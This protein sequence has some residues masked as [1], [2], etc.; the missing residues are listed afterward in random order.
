MKVKDLGEFGLIEELAKM[1]GKEYIGDDA[2]V[3]RGKDGR[4]L[5]YSSD[6]LVEGVHFLPEWHP[7]FKLG[8]KAMCS[9]VSDIA[10]MGG[11]AEY[12]L[13]SIAVPE[14]TELGWVK[15]LYRGIADTG[16]PIIGGDTV[17]GKE[18]VISISIIGSTDE[19]HL[20]TRSGAK[21]GDHVLVSGPLGASR[22]GLEVLK[23]GMEG[24]AE[25]VE[26]HLD[27]GCRS[28]IGHEVGAIANS[29]IDIS[30]GLA[31]EIRHIA[32]MSG[33]GAELYA[34]EIPIHPSAVKVSE[35]LGMDALRIALESGEEYE[36]LFTVPEERLEEARKYGTVIGRIVDGGVYLVRD[37]KRE[38]IG[39]GW[40]QF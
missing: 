38:D 39:K 37:G 20:T 4:I 32:E 7:P 36:L 31:S 14:N 3:V 6:M 40:V 28:D 23:R 25:A 17:R 24:Y 16:V 30:D 34:E 26:K 13:V 8:R 18:V 12:A 29:M 33:V 19:E 35:A 5:L 27:P 1:I 2:A 22:A 21:V 9:N 15:D 11:V 10:A